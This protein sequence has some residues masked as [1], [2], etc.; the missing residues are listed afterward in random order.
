MKL[1]LTKIKIAQA[2][3]INPSYLTLI[4]RDGY[5]P[6][7][8]TVLR[9]ARALHVPA[10]E[11]LLLAGYSPKSLTPEHLEQVLQTKPYP[12][13]SSL[14]HDLRRM[15]DEEQREVALVLRGLVAAVRSER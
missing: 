12:L 3:E 13:P 8:V 4:E 11:A 1:K 14:V 7:R 9:V 6:T 10:S 5:I 2:A 15:S